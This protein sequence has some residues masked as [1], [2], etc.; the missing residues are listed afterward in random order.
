MEDRTILK[1]CENNSQLGEL[2]DF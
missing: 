1:L 2:S